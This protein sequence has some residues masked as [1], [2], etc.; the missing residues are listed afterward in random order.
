MPVFLLR[1][2]VVCAFN[3][4]H[5]F[6]KRIKVVPEIPSSETDAFGKI[7]IFGALYY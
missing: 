5:L 6:V 3:S 4:H 2:T 1:L 7:G